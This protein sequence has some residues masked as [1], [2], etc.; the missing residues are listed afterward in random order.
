MP[1]I[2]VYTWLFI[3][4]CVAGVIGVLVVLSIIVMTIIAIIDKNSQIRQ[5][6]DKL[7]NSH[8]ENNEKEI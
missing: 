7:E 6:E 5:W 8:C 2:E 3:V 4:V 1:T